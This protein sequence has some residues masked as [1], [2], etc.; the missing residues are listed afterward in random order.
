LKENYDLLVKMTDVNGKPFKIV[1]IPM[2]GKVMTED[3]PLPASYLNFYIGDD[4]VCVPIFGH[5]NDKKALEIIQSLFP[6][7]KVVGINCV[8]HVYGL[9][10]LHCSSQQQPAFK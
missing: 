1:K 4:A 2:P 3:R 9:G 10:T 8:A 7:H 5:S 6:K